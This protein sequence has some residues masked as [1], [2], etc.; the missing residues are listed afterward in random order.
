MRF[1]GQWLQGTDDLSA[2][3]DVRVDVFC[4]EQGYSR[5]M[6]LDGRD[7]DCLHYVLTDDQ[8]HKAVATGRLF[9]TDGEGTMAVGRIAVRKA[10]RGYGLGK[11]IMDAMVAKAQEL[12]AA[13]LVLDSQCYAIGFYEKCG[14]TV[15]GEEHM[16]GHVPHK[17]MQRI[18]GKP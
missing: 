2:C 17:M 3:Y 18:L 4:D 8:E 9:W 1:Q 10:W 7:G 6:E 5:E 15:C 14:F 13:R 12:H 11:T 16:D